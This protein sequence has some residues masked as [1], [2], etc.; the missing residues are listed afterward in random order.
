MFDFASPPS[1]RV[2]VVA[3]LFL[4]AIGVLALVAPRGP[5]AA[6]SAGGKAEICPNA[7]GNPVEMS[8]SEAVDAVRCLINK[9]RNAHGLGGFN[10][11]GNLDASAQHHTDRM[12]GGGCFSHEC[13]GEPGIATRIKQTGYLGGAHS[14]GVGE[15]IA[16]GMRSRGE[17]AAV[18]EAWMHSADHRAAI[19]NGQFDDLG[20]GMT[21]GTPQNPN[22][23]GATY[24]LD[25]GYAHG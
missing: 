18:V 23:H 10:P 14:W 6:G 20:V 17:P 13:S 5:W 2:R 25:F 24:T 7:H 15:N 16:Y 9:R 8:H 3:V 1:R 11:S 22:G 19:L 4:A 12:V 21:P